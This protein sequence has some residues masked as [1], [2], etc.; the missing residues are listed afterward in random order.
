MSVAYIMSRFPKLTE[1]FILYEIIA[2]QEQG[3]DVALYPLWREQTSVMHL[4]ARPLVAQ[5]NY[6]P[7]L[8]WPIIKATL[9]YLRRQPRPI[10]GC[11][12][13]A[14][15]PQ[16]GQPALLL[17]GAGDSP[18]ERPLCS[19]NGG[20]WSKPY[21]RSFRQPP[22]GGKNIYVC[23]MKSGALLPLM[24]SSRWTRSAPM[25][26]WLSRHFKNRGRPHRRWSVANDEH[27]K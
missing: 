21:P 9:N 14:A 11:R 26:W 13:G 2:L 3:V 12:L 25:C 23:A 22:G 24:P 27:E 18:Q 7:T 5:A 16:L 8:S 10:S 15:S 20:K 19:R 6:Q 17:W 4:E 1:T